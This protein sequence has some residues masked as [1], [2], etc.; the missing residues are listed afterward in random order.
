MKALHVVHG[1]PVIERAGGTERYVHALAAATGAPE[2]AFEPA[3]DG[4]LERLDAPY[5]LYTCG[6]SGSPLTFRETWSNPHF[7]AALGEVL[8]RERPDII[9]A[10]HF[11]HGGF[12]WVEVAAA[13]GVPWVVTLHDFHT[14]CARGQMVTARTEPCEG[15]DATRCASCLGPHLHATPLTQALGAI[16]GR[17]GVRELAKRELG[18][19]PPGERVVERW[20]ARERAANRALEGASALIS[21][22]KHLAQRFE[23]EGW[24]VVQLDLPLLKQVEP[25]PPPTGETRLLFVGA[26]IPSKGPDLLLEAVR[27]LDERCERP[28]RVDLWGPLQ[29]WD[30]QP[31]WEERLLAL[32][33][34]TPNAFYNGTFSPDDRDDVYGAAD[35]LVVPSRWPE[36]S[37]LVV[38]EALGA[39]LTVVG[40][41]ATGVEEI[42]PDAITVPRDDREALAAALAPLCEQ[43]PQRRAP[44]RW[45]LDDHLA[46]LERLYCEALER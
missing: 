30:G 8:D 22:S 13:R 36:N 17:I 38:R 39:G 20:R 45:P 5:P 4:F 14:L 32:A 6:R 41:E 21:P 10:H 15:P 9:H 31:E 37:P 29:P 18:E 34:E 11:A 19:R 1:S 35:V 27:L 3:R 46:S 16:A 28:P 24:Q 40:T 7:D 25:R 42:D 26:M 2:L 33:R 23:R 43:R 44:A 12:T